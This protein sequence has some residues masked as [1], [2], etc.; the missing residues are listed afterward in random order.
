HLEIVL[1]PSVGHLGIERIG[2]AWSEDARPLAARRC[3][4]VPEQ[5]LSPIGFGGAM[6]RCAGLEF[7]PTPPPRHR[8]SIA[9]VAG[10]AD[11]GATD[12]RV[13]GVVHPLDLRAFA[14]V[15]FWRVK[16][17]AAGRAGPVGVG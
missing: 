2:E 9:I 4:A 13:E 5:G 1:A 15:R 10:R 12:P 14:H 17:A 11:P 6:P 8:R 16:M 7:G 3:L